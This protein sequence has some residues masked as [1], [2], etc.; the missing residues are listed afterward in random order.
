MKI[1][2]RVGVWAIILVFGIPITI[3][4]LAG[5]WQITVGLAGILGTLGSKLI[6]SEEKGD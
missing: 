6:E 4:A 5:E 1:R 3:G 2:W